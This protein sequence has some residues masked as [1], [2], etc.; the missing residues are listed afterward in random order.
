[1]SRPEFCVV[2]A[3]CLLHTAL[4]VGAHGQPGLV[5]DL[6]FAEPF[7]SPCL[8]RPSHMAL[9]SSHGHPKLSC[10]WPA[11]RSSPLPS[12]SFPLPLAPQPPTLAPLS[13]PLQP[14]R[15]FTLFYCLPQTHGSWKCSCSGA[16]YCA[17]SHLLHWHRQPAGREERRCAVPFRTAGAGPAEQTPVN[18]CG[19]PRDT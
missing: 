8:L 18:M 17:L 11:G 10:L 1:M 12:A 6:H 15:L 4:R 7:R 16:L 13:N 9:P 5:R 19:S 2:A 14:S 3:H